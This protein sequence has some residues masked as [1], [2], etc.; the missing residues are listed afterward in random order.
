MRLG[1][2]RESEDCV[3]SAWLEGEDLERRL[4]EIM[5]DPDVTRVWIRATSTGSAYD[6][7]GSDN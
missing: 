7:K 3:T 5:P 6:L 4:A 1:Y 2:V